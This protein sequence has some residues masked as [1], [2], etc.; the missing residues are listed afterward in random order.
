MK[1]CTAG[2]SNGRRRTLLF[3]SRQPRCTRAEPT[4]D[5]VAVADFFDRVSSPARR[6]SPCPPKEGCR[7]GFGHLTTSPLGVG[8]TT[9]GVLFV[10]ERIKRLYISSLS[11]DIKKDLEPRSD[12]D[13]LPTIGTSSL[14]VTQSV[15]DWWEMLASVLGVPR[16]CWKYSHISAYFNPK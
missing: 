16:R 14:G 8:K 12:V 5:R 3:C 11:A 15:K 7:T 6:R 2:D 4:A 10:G 1:L 9:G 13:R